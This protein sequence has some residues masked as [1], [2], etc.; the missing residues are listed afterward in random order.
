[1][2]ARFLLTHPAYVVTTMLDD[3]Y[4]AGAFL[5]GATGSVDYGSS[6][7]VLPGFAEAVFWPQSRA[8]AVVAGVVLVPLGALAA[9]GI[10]TRRALPPAASMSAALLV[11]AAVS[12]LVVAHTAGAAY[13]RLLM[14]TGVL[15][16]VTVIWLVV[17]ALAG[18]ARVRATKVAA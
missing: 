14:A 9:R 11:V 7:A 10:V 17:T 18:P 15:A 1:V 8:D 13:P 12:I 5:G 6:R 2:Y 3:R 16:R 4:P